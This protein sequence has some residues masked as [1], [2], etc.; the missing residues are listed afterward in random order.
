MGKEL[1]IVYNWSTGL[2]NLT[3][4]SELT[5]AAFLPGVPRTLTT[6]ALY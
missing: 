5:N 2:T 3:L 4:V 6:Q 1:L